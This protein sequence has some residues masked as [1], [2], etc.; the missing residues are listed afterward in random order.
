MLRSTPGHTETH[1]ISPGKHPSMVA[2]HRTKPLVL[3]PL[4]HKKKNPT[5]IWLQMHLVKELYISTYKNIN[6]MY[7]KLVQSL[8]LVSDFGCNGLGPD[9]IFR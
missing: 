3:W 9:A 5:S 1:E 4:S 7:D 6:D 2:N 8:E